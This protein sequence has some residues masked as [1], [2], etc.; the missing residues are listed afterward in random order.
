MLD[1][2]TVSFALRGLGGVS[3]R[4]LERK[5]SEICMSV[6]TLAELRYGA[7]RRSSRKLHAIIDAF[8]AGVTV[9]SFDEAAAA[10]FGTVAASLVRQGTTIGDFDALIAAHALSLDLTLVTNNT[11]HFSRVDGLRIDNWV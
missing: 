10:R 7:D 11:K 6:I 3:T 4:L 1:T 9:V 2:D 8:A 5:P